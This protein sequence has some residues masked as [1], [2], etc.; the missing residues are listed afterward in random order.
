[1][2]KVS[3]TQIQMTRGDTLRVRVNITLDGEAY[4]PEEGD[5][6]AFYLKHSAFNIMRTDYKDPEP[7]VTKAVPISTMVLTLDPEDT[8]PLDFGDYVYDLE[9]TFANGTVDTFINNAS[10]TLEPEVG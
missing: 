2:I 3:G 10:L 6:I 9:L 5:S 1:M 7:L 8:K 4:T